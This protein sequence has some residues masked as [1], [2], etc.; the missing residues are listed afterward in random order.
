ME[1]LRETLVLLSDLQ[2]MDTR[3]VN[4]EQKSLTLPK[5]LKKKTRNH[6]VKV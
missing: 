5:K 6:K 1:N 4:L 3:I 2:D